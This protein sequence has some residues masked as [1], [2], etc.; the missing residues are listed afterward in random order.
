M[1]NSTCSLVLLTAS[2][3]VSSSL[4]AQ[5]D[6][7]PPPPPPPE[8]GVPSGG[9]GP[10][11]PDENGGGP[12]RNREQRGN[13]N[14]E[15][16]RARMMTYLREQFGVTKDDEWALISERI[17]A[18]NEARR[19]AGPGF[20]GGFRGPGGPGGPGGFGGG[21]PG[22][23]GDRPNR[24]GGLGGSPEAE[25]LRAAV[26]DNLPN[27]EI[28]ARLAKLRE[29]RKANEAKLAKAQEDLRAVLNVKQEAVAVLNG[30][31]P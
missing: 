10:G 22:G 14:P 18:V 1:K 2:L 31:L 11:G 7:A 19:A 26:T 16:M 12:R 28:Q 9:G 4:F 23:G 13:F 20:G 15:E 27:A 29:T 24:R 8:A 5:T 3:A 25:A 21:G 30:L 6:V 17:N